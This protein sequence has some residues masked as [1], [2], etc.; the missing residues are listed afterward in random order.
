MRT[1]HVL[2]LASVL[3]CVAGASAQQFNAVFPSAPHAAMNFIPFGIG[4]ATAPVHECVQHQVFLSSLFSTVAGSTPVSIE[5]IAFAPGVN[6]VYRAN[7]TIRLGYTNAVPGVGSASGGLAV[8]VLGGG[9]AP[10]AAGTMH[11][12]YSNPDY[13]ADFTAQGAAN[14]QM[15]LIGTPFIYDHAQGNLLV[16]I[17]SS[18]DRSLLG[19]DLTVSRHGASAES[20]RAYTSNRFAPGEAPGNGTRMEFS[21]SVA[22]PAGCYANCDSSTVQPVLNVDDFSCFV[23]EYAL[24]VTLPPSQQISH[25]ANCDGS[26]VEPVL[27]VDDFSCFINQYAQGCP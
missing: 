16:E 5:R 15:V 4:T 19:T 9:G 7:I 1:A 8:P 25:Y 18:A 20:S 27:N 10:N 2:P 14:F 12:F 21:F 17:V 3:A 22:G 24:A 26:T 13:S 6:G 23:N 11:T